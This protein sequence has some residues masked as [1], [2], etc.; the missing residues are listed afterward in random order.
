M[1]HAEVLEVDSGRWYKR[2]IPKR[3]WAK[4]LIVLIIIAVGATCWALHINHR[5]PMKA[6]TKQAV[7]PV[8]TTPPPDI[9][10][11]QKAQYL[12]SAGQYQAAQ[13]AYQQQAA[14]TT[15]TTTK[16]GVYYQ[17][18]SLAVENKDYTAAK[19]YANEAMQLDPNSP[20][21][22]V[23]LAQIAQA[24]GN[25]SVAKQYYQDAI[26]HV[27]PDMPGYN[28]IRADYQSEMD[29]LP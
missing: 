26:N 22:Y 23:A 12:A 21:P 14:S 10:L 5:Q 27:T 16:L 13:Q 2:L 9:S 18:S 17:Q 19:T 29:A 1:V 3:W 8:T 4:L 15:D 25:D 20:T 6:Q 11:G 28:I 7:T 24:Q